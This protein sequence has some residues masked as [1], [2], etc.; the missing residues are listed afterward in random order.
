MLEEIIEKLLVNKESS[1][2]SETQRW[3]SGLAVVSFSSNGR[4]DEL[5]VE[6]NIL[7]NSTSVAGNDGSI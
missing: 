1:E 3:G 7:Q 2:K 4:S 6:F 5:E